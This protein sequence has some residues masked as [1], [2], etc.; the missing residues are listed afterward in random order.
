MGFFLHFDGKLLSIVARIV[1]KS[2]PVKTDA[3]RSRRSLIPLRNITVAG[4]GVE[5]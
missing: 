4:M 1:G 2:N 3:G 5:L